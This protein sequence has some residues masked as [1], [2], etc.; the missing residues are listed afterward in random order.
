MLW[1]AFQ[2]GSILALFMLPFELFYL[3]HVYDF[4]IAQEDMK[5]DSDHVI[6]KDQP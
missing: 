1:N 5:D 3:R 2:K 4:G 6:W